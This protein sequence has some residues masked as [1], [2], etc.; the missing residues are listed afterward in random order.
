MRPSAYNSSHHYDAAPRL[1][2]NTP[3]VAIH[4]APLTHSTKTSTSYRKTQIYMLLPRVLRRP[5][6]CYLSPAPPCSAPRRLITMTIKETTPAQKPKANAGKTEVKILMLH[7]FT[8]SGALFRAKTRALEKLLTKALAPLNI[9]PVLTYPTG[10][11]R[12]LASD[13]PGYEPPEDGE[14]ETYQPDTWAWF[15]KDEVLGEYRFFDD[16]MRTVADAIREAGGVDGVCGFSQGA[17]MSGMIA[18]ALE[19]ARTPLRDRRETGRAG[20]ERPITSSRSNSPFAT[21]ASLPLWNLSSGY[22]TPRLRQRR[23]IT[24]EASIPWSK[25]AGAKALPTDVRTQ[26]SWYTQEDIMCRCQRNGPCLWP[27]SSSSRLKPANT[28]PKC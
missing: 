18:A 9:L 7:G 2:I 17:A 22:T 24:L 27:D 21:R 28:R 15:R 14:D 11:N 10:P 19:P 20:S 5:I 12:L 16:G 1:E 3:Q 26:L 25:R 23:C 6:L 13:L 8:Q 4:P